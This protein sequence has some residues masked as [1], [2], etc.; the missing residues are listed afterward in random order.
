[1]YGIEKPDVS[2]PIAPHPVNATDS[3]TSSSSSLVSIQCGPRCTG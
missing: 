1:M 2:R 3:T